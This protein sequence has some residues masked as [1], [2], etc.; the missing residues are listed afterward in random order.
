MAS[1]QEL[2]A[3]LISV[4]KRA[5]KQAVFAVRDDDAALDIVQDAMIKLAEKY[6]DKPEA[7]L[8]LLFQRILQNTIHDWFRRTKVRN[9]WVS[10]FSSFRTD[11]DGDETDPLELIES[12][13]GST[14]AESSADKVERA[15]VLEI[16]ERE[17]GEATGTST[18]GLLDALL[19]RHGCCRDSPGHG[20]FRGQCEDALLA[21][22]ARPRASAPGA[23]NPTMNPAE[24]RERRFAHAVHT[25]LNESAG[26]LPPDVRDRL[27]AARRTAIARK[28]AEAPQ[29]V[30]A[31]AL[32]L[33]GVGSMSL[34]ADGDAPSAA[35]KVLSLLRRLGLLWPAIALVAGLA[36]IYQWQQQQRVDELA[37]VDTA[38]MLDDLPLAAYADQGFH[39]YLK[40]DQ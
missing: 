5:F 11:T 15:Q 13:A 7:E 9:T 14:A 17:I 20:L 26:Q 4:E 3:F 38:M 37:E 12:E 25:A 34:D 28:K 22:N 24:L 29:T 30:H 35:R 19:G 10:L 23:R 27:A 32:A 2:S 33:P 36:G 16:L 18:G 8:P 40:R 31:P 6:G 1:E 21:G 39:Q